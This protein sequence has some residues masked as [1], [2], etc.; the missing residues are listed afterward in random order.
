[1]YDGIPHLLADVIVDNKK[2]LSALKWAI[3]EMEKRYKLLQS[4]GSRDIAS[5]NQ[6][7]KNGETRHG[8]IP[9]QMKRTRKLLKKFHT[10]L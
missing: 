2:V 1:M 4:A 6:K 8:Q 10:S 7:A 9:K 3:G 5:F